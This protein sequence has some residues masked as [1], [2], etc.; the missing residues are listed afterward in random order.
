[1]RSN[2]YDLQFHMS[3]QSKEPLLL[4]LDS[5]PTVSRSLQRMLTV[6][7]EAA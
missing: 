7:E 2:N 5:A 1:M 4:S 3:T 6:P